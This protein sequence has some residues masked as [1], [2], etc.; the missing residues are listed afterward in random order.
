MDFPYC[1]LSRMLY[2][3]KLLLDS[4]IH[5]ESNLQKTAIQVNSRKA[6]FRFLKF[7][8]AKLKEASKQQSIKSISKYKDFERN[9][10]I[11]I[12]K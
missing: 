2:T 12:K 3:K 4:D 11:E 9:Q 6:L 1:Q 5:Y 8:K 7:E 10:K